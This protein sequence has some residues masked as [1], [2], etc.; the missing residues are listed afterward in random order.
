MSIWRTVFWKSYW[1]ALRRS[2]DDKRARLLALRVSVLLVFVLS[3][4]LFLLLPVREPGGVW[5]F[6]SY[7]VMLGGALLMRFLL[8]R[9]S[10]RQDEL[11]SYSLTSSPRR[12]SD[13]TAHVSQAVRNYLAE[14]ASIVGSLIARAASEIYI[15]HN[16]LSPGMQVMT[17][18]VQN[19]LL[20]DRELWEKLEP[21]ER[22][23]T[24]LADGRWSTEQQNEVTSWCERLRL[25]RWV[26]GLDAE[27]VPLAHFPKIDFA[28]SLDLPGPE[29]ILRQ[30]KR[31]LGSW[32]V[33]GER[34]IALAYT[35]RAF[36]ELKA[37]G[38]ITVDPKLEDWA[39]EFRKES[40][41]ASKDYVAG[42][43]TIEE[44]DDEALRMFAATAAARERYA[45]YL[46]DQLGAKNPSSFHIWS[47]SHSISGAGSRQE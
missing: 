30:S 1:I 26:L 23:L 2:K 43:K 9:S 29:D 11:L 33:R 5:L 46:V 28:L 24:V 32:D 21:P 41:G 36:A 22:A 45:A 31:V 16:E 15:H 3:Y 35:A 47:E 37:R 34:D 19:A 12:T 13:R 8:N 17:R 25:L 40:L 6:G 44:L 7:G 4:I 27:L 38:L 18:Q 14:R 42:T 39:D 10:R 20:R